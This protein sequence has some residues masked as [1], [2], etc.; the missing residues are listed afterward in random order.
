MYQSLSCNIVL[1]ESFQY[2]SLVLDFVSHASGISDS[3]FANSFVNLAWSVVMQIPPQI[4]SNN[5]LNQAAG[6]NVSYYQ[7]MFSCLL[8]LAQA[9]EDLPSP[10]SLK[11][12][13]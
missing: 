8:E 4:C 7:L 13:S 5:T 11:I 9:I 12:S 6:I 10:N 3:I 2:A 1:R